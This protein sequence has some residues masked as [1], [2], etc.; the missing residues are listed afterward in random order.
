MKKNKKKF[1]ICVFEYV[2]A[3]F[4]RKK[5]Q[6]KWQIQTNEPAINGVKCAI[7]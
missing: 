7:C 4:C 5:N 2:R 6:K 3:V 1:I